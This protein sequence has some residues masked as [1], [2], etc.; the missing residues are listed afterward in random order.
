MPQE[1]D[2]AVAWVCKELGRCDYP[3]KEILIVTELDE[4]LMEDSLVALGYEVKTMTEEEV[5]TS[6]PLYFDT[7]VFMFSFELLVD[8]RGMM[9]RLRE[10]G[11][12]WLYSFGRYG[13]P[14]HERGV[15]LASMMNQ[16]IHLQR[17]E[18]FVREKN[19]MS[20]HFRVHQKWEDKWQIKKRDATRYMR[21]D[22]AGL[23]SSEY[24]KLMG[25]AGRVKGIGDDKHE[26]SQVKRLM[27]NAKYDW[28]FVPKPEERFSD[29]QKL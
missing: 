9:N 4:C 6:S 18:Y 7:A 24:D 20:T 12:E 2:L 29:N 16:W 3:T 25:A 8:R 15:Y 11:V 10:F 26:N 5:R 17:V 23:P 1:S 19:P 27:K 13:N 21:V 22:E 14:E 28:R